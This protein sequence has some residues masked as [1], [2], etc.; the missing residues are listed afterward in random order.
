MKLTKQFSVLAFVLLAACQPSVSSTAP[1][2][3]LNAPASD[4]AESLDRTKLPAGFPILAEMV[5]PTKPAQC[6]LSKSTREGSSSAVSGE[7][8]EG[9]YVFTY[10]GVDEATNE[11]LYQVGVNGVLRTV[12][13]SGSAD[14]GAKT[15]RYF[16]TVDAPEVEV[17]VA[18]EPNGD[19]GDVIGTFGRIKAWDGDA[20]L[21]CAYNIIQVAG[22]CDL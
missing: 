21:M 12:K 10:K 2:A 19:N 17:M 9:R 16:K 7:T 14:R 11:P 1:I 3:V 18:I 22:D 20:P 15:I 13:Q 8:Y 4:D 5:L 6:G